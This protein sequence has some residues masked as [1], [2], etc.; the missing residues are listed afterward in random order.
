MGQLCGGGLAGNPRGDDLL[1]GGSFFLWVMDIFC[2]GAGQ[3][4]YLSRRL[5]PAIET[6]GRPTG[7]RKTRPE[8]CSTNITLLSCAKNEKKGVAKYCWGAGHQKIWAKTTP[9]P[10]RAFFFGVGG[11]H[12]SGIEHPSGP[13]VA[14]Q[15][16]GKDGLPVL[17]HQPQDRRLGGAAREAHLV[18]SSMRR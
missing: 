10:L 14:Q 3:V 6:Q 11:G 7:G 4:G 9:T 18:I 1:S 17:G 8:G 13:G 15:P 16:V 2:S 5:Q 12:S